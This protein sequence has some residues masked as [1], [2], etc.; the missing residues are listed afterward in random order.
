MQEHRTI[1]GSTP[2]RGLGLEALA[3]S[4]LSHRTAS[5][6]TSH[7]AGCLANLD[8]TFEE[9]ANSIYLVYIS[10]WDGSGSSCIMEVV[11][12]TTDRS[13]TSDPAYHCDV[14]VTDRLLDG[15]A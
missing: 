10:I 14:I 5:N 13:I 3:F 1:P 15:I 7:A 12:I 6:Q 11:R 2:G 8:R 9:G 4:F